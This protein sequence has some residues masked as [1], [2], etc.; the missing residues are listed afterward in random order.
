MQ[1]IR[2]KMSEF[3]RNYAVPCLSVTTIVSLFSAGLSAWQ[4][5]QSS[6][7][8][9]SALRTNELL[10]RRVALLEKENKALDDIAFYAAK[11]AHMQRDMLITA[12]VATDPLPPLPITDFRRSSK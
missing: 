12:G 2:E 10:E 11:V 7:I 6:S 5:N 4:S 3:W 1:A 8:T 9:S